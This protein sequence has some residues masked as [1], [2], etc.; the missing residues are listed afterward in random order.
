M[1]IRPESS[2]SARQLRREMTEAER[3]KLG[4]GGGIKVAEVRGPAAQAGLRSG[5]VIVTADGRPVTE[6]TIGALLETKQ[7]GDALPVEVARGTERINLTVVLG[8]R[9]E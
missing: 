3:K 4:I 6:D 1:A 9:K 2:D 8:E 5:D 7:P